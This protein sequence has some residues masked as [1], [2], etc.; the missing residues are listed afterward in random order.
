MNNSDNRKKL[1]ITMYSMNIGGAERSLIGLLNSFDYKKYSVSLMLYQHQGDFMKYIPKEVN[2]L[3]YEP[4]YDVFEVPIRNLLFS[5]KFI[6]GL[7]RILSR[8]DLNIRSKV[9]NKKIGVWNKSQYA[10]KYLLPLLPKITGEYDL[11]LS[12]IGIHNIVLSKVD[13]KVKAGWIH[14]DYNQLTPDRKL[15]IEVYSKLDYIV[16]VSAECHNVFLKHY[17]QFTDK[18]IVV[19]NIL[20]SKVVK[21][22]SCETDVSSEMPDE[23]E[24]LK[25]LSIGRFAYAKNF[26]NIPEICAEIIQKGFKVKWYIIGYGSDEQLIRQKIHEIGMENHVILLGKKENPYPY[27][28]SCDIYIQ[29]SRYEGKAVTVREAQILGKP[30]IITDYET[31]RSQVRDGIDGMIVPMSNEGCAIDI[32]KAITKENL[33]HKISNYC[34]TKDFGNDGEVQKI[35]TLLQNEGTDEKLLFQPE[36]KRCD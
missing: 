22:Q 31:A 20:S 29:P 4:R 26:D 13:A 35:Y 2:L 5:K 33:L 32:M 7:A 12:F 14:T 23:K 25:L 36:L 15:D 17:P 28:L 10:H 6:Y 19:E 18:A 16:N 3:P 1:L 8:I 24:Y 27:I 30:V 34:K 21:Q 9:F 11:A